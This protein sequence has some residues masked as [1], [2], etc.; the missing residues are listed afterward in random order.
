MLFGG[1]IISHYSSHFHHDYRLHQETA[2]CGRLSGGE[3]IRR[4]PSR[5]RNSNES[6]DALDTI[7]TELDK[8][9]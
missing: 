1:G 7:P 8:R 2:V 4:G 5:T 9:Y 3:P 6:H